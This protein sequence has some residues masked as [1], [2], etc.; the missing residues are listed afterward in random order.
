LYQLSLRNAHQ[1]EVEA[2]I[3]YLETKNKIAELTLELDPN[4]MGTLM[5]MM[6]SNLDEDEPGDKRD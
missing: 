2:L 6:M 4:A 3:G 5:N 1:G